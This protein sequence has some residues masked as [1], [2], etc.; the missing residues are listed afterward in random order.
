M[1]NK[2]NSSNAYSCRFMKKKRLNILIL[3]FL[4]NNFIANFNLSN[5]LKNI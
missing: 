3:I 1:K 5:K 2:N 4:I